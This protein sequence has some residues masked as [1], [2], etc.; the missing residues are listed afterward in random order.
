[1]ASQSIPLVSIIIPVFNGERYLE[2]TIKSTIAN[3]E[4]TDGRFA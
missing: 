2:E 4:F 3:A 1:M